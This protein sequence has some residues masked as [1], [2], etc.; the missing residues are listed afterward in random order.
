MGIFKAYDIRGT[1]PAQLDPDVARKIGFHFAQLLTARRLVVGQDMRTHSPEIADAV[2]E[3]IRDAG[4]DVLR[5]GLASTPMTYYAIGALDCDGG[6]C[7]TAS[8]NPG[9]YNGMK[10][11]SQGARP[12]SKATGIADIEARCQGDDPVPVAGRGVA[13][14]L[15]VLNEY[16]DHV[17]QFANLERFTSASTPPMA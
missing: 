8:H 3:G 16:A 14:Q 2:S 5:L 6:L 11:C 9:E 7:V 13:E 17:M 12:I 10:L 15:D 1:V 4:C